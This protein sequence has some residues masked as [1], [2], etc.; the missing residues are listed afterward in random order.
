VRFARAEGIVPAPESNH[1]IRVAIDEALACRESGEKRV[2]LFNLSGHG[3]F[4]L[5]AYE[6]FLAEKLED[7]S[8]TPKAR[9][10]E[11]AIV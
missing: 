8:Y 5:A 4:D 1:A 9:E 3:H 2:I 11:L 10:A 6:A 7:Y